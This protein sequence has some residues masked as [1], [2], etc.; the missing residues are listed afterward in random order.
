MIIRRT[1]P[2]VYAYSD[3]TKGKYWLTSARSKKWGLNERK[4]FTTEQAALNYARQIEKQITAYGK[5]PNLNAAD[6]VAARSYQRLIQKL[7]AHGCTPEGAAEH[8]VKHVESVANAQTKPTIGK[9]VNNWESF[10]LLDTSLSNRTKTEIRS[11]ARF[12][13]SRWGE[14]RTTELKKNEIAEVLKKLKV[15]NNTR[16]KYLRYIR[17]FFSWLRDE[18][19]IPQN[20]TDGI[21]FK[22]DDFQAGFYTPEET[23]HLL[24][25]V[26]EHEKDLI[27]YYALLTFAGLRPTE[28]ERVLW[29]DYS[30]D[31][32]ELYVRKGKT[33]ARYIH[34]P[35]VAQDWVK[36]H[37]EN[38]PQGEPF[39]NLKNLGNRAKATR[40]AVS[41]GKWYQDG[42]RHGFATYFKAKTKSVAEVADYMGSSV[43]MVK[44]HYARTIPWQAPIC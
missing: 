1:F 18:G 36:F 4:T 37:R 40:K 35:P 15:S 26:V 10:K 43:G 3:S 11:Y 21:L 42:L 28:G 2:Q 34:L 38:T 29:E 8:Y 20:P 14:R 44:R 33:A 19:H 7:A 9:L 12:I 32:H 24:R 39:I 5:Q 27:G 16:R 17:M 13:R 31:T 30:F 23:K 6:H 41:D 25:F 22:A